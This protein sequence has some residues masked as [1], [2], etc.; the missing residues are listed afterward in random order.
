MSL[1]R[2]RHVLAAAVIVSLV[3]EINTS[4]FF[5]LLSTHA[6]PKEM[7]LVDV[8]GSM[9]S[10][11]TLLLYNACRPSHRTSFFAGVVLNAVAATMGCLMADDAVPWLLQGAALEAAV[12]A[13]GGALILMP[14]ITVLGKTSA[15][16][17]HEATVYSLALSVL[18]LSAVGSETVAAAAMRQLHVTKGDVNNVRVFVGVV[19]VI[20][21]LTAPAACLFPNNKYSSLQQREEEEEDEIEL[22]P[23]KKITVP[24]D[25]TF[26]LEDSS[27]TSHSSSREI[28]EMETDTE[29]YASSESENSDTL[30]RNMPRPLPV[31]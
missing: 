21:V 17:K 19:A 12:S 10:L 18:N 22:L 24:H 6:T 26:T 13:V 2:S 7:S 27:D 20:T 14:T 28:A 29:P 23:K 8:S 25:D 5:Y 15:S 3:P 9:A 4:L 30:D 31:V 16:S 11:L 1:L